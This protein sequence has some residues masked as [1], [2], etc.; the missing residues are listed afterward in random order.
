M[1]MEEGMLVLM[2]VESDSTFNRGWELARVT[3][4]G[5]GAAGAKTFN[6][7][8]LMPKT[9][10]QPH[11]PGGRGGRGRGEG[12]TESGEG[13]ASGL[14][15]GTGSGGGTNIGRGRGRSTGRGRGRGR[16]ARGGRGLG[17]STRI[18]YD[19]V[20]RWRAGWEERPFED[21]EV[22]RPDRRFGVWDFA[23]I[24]TGVVVWGHL[25]SSRGSSV[26]R[27]QN[28]KLSKKAA[29]TLRAAVTWL[30][31]EG[32]TLR[33]AAEAATVARQRASNAAMQVAALVRQRRAESSVGDNDESDGEEGIPAENRV[34]GE[35]DDSDVELEVR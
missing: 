7:V 16:G 1:D 6:G 24:D 14:G 26:G 21:I 25:F 11:Q 31:D 20:E 15:N 29:A 35:T 19:S 34:D 23:G 18:P 30:E 8:Y 2:A 10:H 12:S 3:G 32:Q 33:E 9:P 17:A 27:H 28:W 22:L 4:L 13:A 5:V